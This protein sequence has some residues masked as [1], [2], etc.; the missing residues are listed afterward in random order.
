MNKTNFIG[1]SLTLLG[2]IFWGVSGTCA[3]YLQINQHINTPWLLTTRLFTAGLITVLYELIRNPKHCLAVFHCKQDVFKLLIFGI[4]GIA[5]CQ[6]SYFVTI[7]YA[8]AGIATVIQY[9]AP[10]IIILYMFIV[11]HKKPTI[12]EIVSVFLASTGTIIIALH[13]EFSLAKLNSQVLFWGLTSAA[14]VAIYSVQPVSLIKK[15][16]TLPIVGWGMIAG[17]IISLAIWEPLSAEAIIDKNTLFSFFG[18]I[19]I[20]TVFAF[21]FYLEGVRRI[22]AIQGSILA[23]TEPLSAAFISWLF[24]NNIYTTS[25]IIG[26][27]LILSTIFILAFNKKKK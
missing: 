17:S 8:G 21:N 24:L 7:I 22:G 2:A 27:C 18:V 13:G 12:A 6:Y 23:S 4:L 9:V 15:Y 11:H 3:Q 20:G 19:I 25:D 5:L 14:A 1:I 10:I 26:F 16:G